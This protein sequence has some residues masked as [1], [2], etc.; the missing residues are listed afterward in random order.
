M[1]RSMALKLAASRKSVH[2]AAEAR[3]AEQKA[4][5][6]RQWEFDH[7][8]PEVWGQP[9]PGTTMEEYNR[10]IDGARERKQN[11]FFGDAWRYPE[12]HQKSAPAVSFGAAIASWFG[13]RA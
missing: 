12:Q 13:L 2:E 7:F 5:A 6:K 9:A 1:N 10:I 8:E 11:V 3:V 4:E